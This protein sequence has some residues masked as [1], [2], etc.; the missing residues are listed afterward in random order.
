MLRIAVNDWARKE[1]E[2][3]GYQGKC[4]DMAVDFRNRFTDCLILANYLQ[5]HEHLVDALI[6][7]LY[8]EY[9]SSRDCKP[10]VWVLVGFITRLAMKM[11]YHQDS[12]PL[13][14]NSP[15]H[16]SGQLVFDGTG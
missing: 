1:D 12:Q 4:D 10:G 7:H 2:P 14:Q 8:A 13:L 15:F 9:A 3:R 5:P 16:V 6:L 11:G